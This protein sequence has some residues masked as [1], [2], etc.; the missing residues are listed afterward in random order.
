M[1]IYDFIC[2]YKMMDDDDDRND[3]YRI[4]ILQAFGLQCYDNTALNNKIAELYYHMKEKEKEKECAPLKEIIEESYKV[5]QHICVCDML[6]FTF[7]FSYDYF[8]LFH[9]CLIDFFTL[10]RILEETKN[11]LIDKIKND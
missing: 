3:L 1:Y 2:T 5:N 9:K 8:D 6:V 11:N 10:G 7:L 4:Q